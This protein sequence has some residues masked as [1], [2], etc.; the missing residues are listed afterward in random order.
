MTIEIITG[1]LLSAKEQYIAHQCNCLTQ[2]SAGTAKAIFDKFPYAN[3]YAARDVAD[4]MG[5]IKIFGNGEDQRYVVNMY[6]QYY[7]GRSKYPAS[8]K[9]GIQARLNCFD[10]C[11]L[12]IANIEGLKNVA[13]PYKIG[14][15]LGGGNW[16]DYLKRLTGFAEHVEKT[17][18]VRVVIYQREGDK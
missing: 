4:T 1:D 7:P 11:L 9:D 5:T 13:F 15:N 6:A 3:S 12:R 14:C 17:K 16:E 18:D 8:D 10:R 2:N